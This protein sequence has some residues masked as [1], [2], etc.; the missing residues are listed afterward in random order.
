M[1]WP[2]LRRDF[3]LQGRRGDDIIPRLREGRRVMTPSNWHRV[4]DIFQSAR[5]LPEGEQSAFLDTACAGDPE[6]RREV[7]ALMEY[8]RNSNGVLDVPA[9]VHLQRMLTCQLESGS[10]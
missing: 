7:E 9:H 10:R 4:E 3:A 8:D 1:P 6:I 2:K 5:T